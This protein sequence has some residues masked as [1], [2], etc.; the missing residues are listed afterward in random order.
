MTSHLSG[1]LIFIGKSFPLQRHIKGKS[2]FLK[3][4]DEFDA[5]F[6]INLCSGIGFA[7]VREI[8]LARNDAI[9]SENRPTKDYLDQTQQRFLDEAGELNLSPELLVQVTNELK[10]FCVWLANVLTTIIT[11]ETPG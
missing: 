6:G 11:T 1:I 3:Q 7:G 2:K 5:R 4:I 10:E 8:I 9:H